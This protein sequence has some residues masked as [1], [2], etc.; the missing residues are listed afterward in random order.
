MG[1][2]EICLANDV[3]GVPANTSRLGGVRVG[4][5]G[6]HSYILTVVGVKHSATLS[7]SEPLITSMERYIGA[8][9]ATEGR[10]GSAEITT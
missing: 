8:S 7:V 10:R 9:T 4:G 1:T 3:N 5:Q 6:K 2:P